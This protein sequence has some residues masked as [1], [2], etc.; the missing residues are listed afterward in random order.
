MKQYDILTRIICAIILFSCMIGC[1]D[2]QVIDGPVPEDKIAIRMTVPGMEV[3]VLSRSDGEITGER[4]IKTIDMLIFDDSAPARLLQHIVITD[5]SQGISK[6]DYLIWFQLTLPKNENIHNARTVAIVANAHE[7]VMTA[8]AQGPL[9]EEKRIILDHLKFSTSQDSQGSYKWNV[10]ASDFTPIPMYGEAM[11]YGIYKGMEIAGI[12]LTRMLARIDIQNEV[13]GSIFK[14]EKIYLVNYRTS[15]YIAPAWNKSNGEILQKENNAY[16][17]SR[18]LDPMIPDGAAPT[19]APIE[20]SYPQTNSS[21]GPLMDGQIY[22]YEAP[23]ASANERVCLVLQG[24][25]ENKTYFYRVDFTSDKEDHENGIDIYL[26][27]E[28]PLYR[29]HKYVVTIKAA[30]G[31]G[32]TSFEQ[33]VK[34]STVLSNLKTSVLVVDMTGINNIVYDG[35][36][37]MGTEKKVLDVPWNTDKVVAHKIRSD[38]HGDWQAKIL[39]PERTGWLRFANGGTTSGGH[40]IN[41]ANLS[42]Q[43]NE[44]NSPWENGER[45][46]GRIAFTTGRL[47]D[48]LMVRRVTMAELFARSNI[49]AFYDEELSF[50]NSVEDHE[51]IHGHYNGMLFKWGSLKP[52]DP[53]AEPFDPS[54]PGYQNWDDIPYAH[55]RFN[56][57]MPSSSNDDTD[58]FKTFNNGLGFNTETGVGDICRYLSNRPG[59]SSGK[60][61]LPTQKE[62]GLLLKETSRDIR[63][64]TWI[65]L[66]QLPN[67]PAFLHG[68]FPMPSGYIL[69]ISASNPVLEQD[70]ICPPEGTVFLPATT[71]RDENGRYFLSHELAHY[72]TSTP[73]GDEASGIMFH[74]GGIIP[75][76]TI[77]SH[78][79]PVRCIRDY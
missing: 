69:G 77:R 54:F 10:S 8:L 37:F 57:T 79:L 58:A 14:L 33:A 36:Y 13:N 63:K 52:I 41:L 78:A 65:D 64:F 49:V 35:Q 21:P 29:N 56:F 75:F 27:D 76:R 44:I 62:I 11:V 34:A 16:P 15:G 42:L 6:D 24:I 12:E 59:W 20:Y 45:V 61:R 18:N 3:P 26:G 4:E 40:D 60:W 72:W 53:I 23:K 43:V 30:E 66:V 31:I 7:E 19:A 25:Y 68:R 28:V 70:L 46:I 55:E 74:D 39:D 5:F 32:Y 22:T 17:Y 48:T 9:D 47:R 2:E 71:Y 73:Y 67:D 38:Y 51:T 1:T 50:A